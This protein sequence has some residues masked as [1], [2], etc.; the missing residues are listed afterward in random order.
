M[1][2]LQPSAPAKTTA[3]TN[4]DLLIDTQAVTLEEAQA[5]RSID[6]NT[7]SGNDLADAEYIAALRAEALPDPHDERETNPSW[8][9]E[10]MR[11]AASEID[12]LC[13]QEG[14]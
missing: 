3:N 4:A 6:N 12:D 10:R 7:G 1:R 14:R 8:L 5:W 2:Q 9:Q 11:V 13:S